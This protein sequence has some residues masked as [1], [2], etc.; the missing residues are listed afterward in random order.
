[1]CPGGALEPKLKPRD[2]S[3]NGYPIDS[4]TP[5]HGFC[6]KFEG[7]IVVSKTHLIDTSIKKGQIQ[8]KKVLLQITKNAISTILGKVRY[9]KKADTSL[10]NRG[11]G[12]IQ[13]KR[14]ILFRTIAE[15]ERYKKKG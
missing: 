13:E 9:K 11:K 2:F 6:A 10:D 8:D 14:L 12:K 3:G 4:Q 1:M 5:W 15:K 7:P